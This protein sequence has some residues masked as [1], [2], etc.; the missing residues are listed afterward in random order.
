MNNIDT[1]IKYLSGDLEPLS[2]MEFEKA[3]ETIPDLAE[4]YRSVLKIWETSK[5]LLSIEELP[6]G[7]NREEFIAEVIA[8]YDIQQYRTK[9]LSK[10]GQQFKDE[11]A[12]VI[13]MNTS[14][15]EKSRKGPIK[16]IYRISIFLVAAA[17]IFIL[18]LMPGSDLIQLA[19]GY[20]N[21]MVDP[22]IEQYNLTVRSERANALL[23]FKEG[24]FSEARHSFEKNTDKA[25]SLEQLFYAITC[26]ETGDQNK[27]FSLLHDLILSNESTVSYKAMWYLSLL[28]IDQGELEEAQKNLLNIS[29]TEGIYKKKSRRLLRKIK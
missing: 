15:S 25:D 1:I 7:T 3:L 18:I 28:L 23:F 8:A 13:Q 6:D 16:V 22:D 12:R 20:Y 17:A 14:S 5:N 29:T 4:E 9:T 21:P 10:K 2:K 27:A 19:S 24:N 26:Y 11:L